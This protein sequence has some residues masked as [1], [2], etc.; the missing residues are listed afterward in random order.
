MNFFNQVPF[1]RILLPFVAGIAI[2]LWGQQ[3]V[4][5]LAVFSGIYAACVFLFLFTL[6]KTGETSK[7]L[8]GITLQVFLF[9]AG[10]FICNFTNER[11]DPQHYVNLLS[12]EPQYFAGFVSEIPA[13]K[14]K[15]IKAEIT[16]QNI[17]IN[18]EWK[19]ADGKIIAYFSKNDSSRQ[20]E[21]GQTIVFSGS[22]QDIQEPLNPHEFDYKKYL[23]LKNIYYS[24]YLKENTWGVSASQN[25]SSLFTFAQKIRKSLLDTY[26]EIGLQQNEFALVAALVLGYDDEIDRP[27][28]NAYSHTGTLHVLSVSGLHVGIIY[29]LLGFILGFLNKNKKQI[30]LKVFLILGFLWFFVLLSGFSAPAVRAALMFSLILIGKTLFENTETANIVFVAAF[31]SLLYNPFWLANAGFQLSYVAVLGIIYLY[32]YFYNMF[33][34]SSGIGDKIW[35]L[36]SVSIAAQ[37]ATLPITLYYF[38]QFPVLFLVTNLVLIPV[39]IVVMYG[40]ILVLIFSK[41]TFLSQAFVWLT[42]ISIKLMNGCALFFDRLPFCVIDNIHLSVLN[43]LLMYLLIVIVFAAIEFRSAKLLT[44]SFVIIVV[45]FFVSVYFD[46]QIKENNELVIYHSD[47]SEVVGVF[48][49]TG[50]TQICDTVDERIL[51]TLRENKIHHDAVFEQTRSLSNANLILAGTKKILF[52][53][54]P[55][56]IS[57]VLMNAANPDYIWLPAR[58]LRGKKIPSLLCQTKNLVITGN[59]YS[60][61]ALN[62]LDSAHLTNKKGALIV[63]LR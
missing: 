52:V 30:W 1:L 13:E 15:S 55:E 34:F 8:Y 50:Y 51:S 21:V 20:I 54:S 35:Q 7:L 12:Q 9:V 61:K 22:L 40:G 57:E 43:M 4:P 25:N 2:W 19:N 32:P 45:M 18:G 24:V 59:T 44:N 46:L 29:V 42:T 3:D 17:R 16:L 39:S 48:D 58:S 10:W 49:G 23:A 14:A 47:K 6:K 27:L 37:I 31:V 5:G 36:C 11:N 41:I 38:H 56:L 62:C 26:R 53:R 33:T 60:K 63:S 28:M